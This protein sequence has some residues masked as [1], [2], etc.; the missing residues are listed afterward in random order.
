MWTRE[1]KRLMSV[2]DWETRLHCLFSVAGGLPDSPIIFA[3]TSSLPHPALGKRL[4]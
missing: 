4:D 1:V 3:T 2:G